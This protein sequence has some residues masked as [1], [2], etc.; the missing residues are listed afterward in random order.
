MYNSLVYKTA[1]GLGWIS[2]AVGA[3]EI[4]APGALSRALG[5]GQHRALVRGFGIRELTSGLGILL[6][7]NPVPW[8]W[9]R[10]AGDV[11]DMTALLPGLGRR[12]RHRGTA[13]GALVSVAA[14]A[15]VD[16]LC[17]RQL[18][19]ERKIPQSRRRADSNHTG[20]HHYSGYY[21]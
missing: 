10:L 18:G 19:D 11:I 2:L 8:L 20:L 14:V 9:T 4:L 21:H 17:A 7:K 1:R 12:N 5:F 15:L 3:V 13:A 6:A 16:Y